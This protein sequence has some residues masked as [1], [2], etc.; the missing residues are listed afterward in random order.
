MLHLE[1]K[2]QGPNRGRWFYKCPAR[3]G[4]GYFLWDDEAKLRESN[5][6]APPPSTAPATDGPSNP[7][8]PPPPATQPRTPQAPARQAK[9]WGADG[10]GITTPPPSTFKSNIFGRWLGRSKPSS[11]SSTDDPDADDDH[12]VAGSPDGPSSSVREPPRTPRP[13]RKRGLDTTPSGKQEVEGDDDEYGDGIDSD[14]ERRMVAL[15]EASEQRRRQQAPSTP[16][17]PGPGGLRTPV[18][19]N[20]LLIAS[21]EQQQR[22][23]KRVR[24]Q[25]EEEPAPTSPC[26]SSATLSLLTP[27]SVVG[28]SAPPNPSSSD[29]Y[30]ITTEVLA[31][32]APHAAALGPAVLTAV[33]RTL[34][35]HALRDVG[36][37]RSRDM[38]RTA[39]AARDTRVAEL[40]MRVA[41]L[42]S[43]QRRDRARTQQ[44]RR[45]L[46][47][48]MG[49]GEEED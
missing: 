15:S 42:E 4:C 10:F 43:G 7:P 48:I 32:L 17:Q 24:F 20:T 16:K 44:M 28:A 11:S 19:R 38:V 31:I 47:A 49:H 30:E 33:R 5:S 9:L 37:V 27:A 3:N 26:P 46:L 8:R 1:T 23:S 13:K 35:S 41:E 6:G 40:Q 25:P 39:L 45:G 2:K 18:S 36:V 12:I 22:A 34:N 14:M 21:E 29:D